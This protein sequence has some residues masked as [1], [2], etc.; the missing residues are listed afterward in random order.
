MYVATPPSFP[1]EGVANR[2]NAVVYLQ[3]HPHAPAR[4]VSAPP[5]RMAGQ[6]VSS[7]G[8]LVAKLH[9]EA[10]VI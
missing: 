2:S 7:V 9:E 3:I 5:K 8:E 4:Q 6:R 1:L 10:K